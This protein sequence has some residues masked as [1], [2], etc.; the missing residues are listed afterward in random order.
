M[1]AFNMGLFKYL[2]TFQNKSVFIK[3]NY[4]KDLNVGVVMIMIRKTPEE[5][6]IWYVLVIQIKYVAVVLLIVF[7]L[8]GII[9][10]IF[11]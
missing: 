4:L 8:Q 7:L 2:I 11:K 1:L 5:I 6:V 10:N 3:F 9:E